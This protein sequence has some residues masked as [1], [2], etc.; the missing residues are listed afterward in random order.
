MASEP[1]ERPGQVIRVPFARGSKSEHAA[2]TLLVGDRRY[3]L[4]RQGGNAFQDPELDALVG[5]T[6]QCKGRLA[7]HTFILQDWSETDASA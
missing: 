4:R 5:R 6:I 2:V 3:V 7:G 1:H